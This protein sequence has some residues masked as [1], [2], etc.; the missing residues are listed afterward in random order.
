PAT[1]APVSAPLTSA[2]AMASLITT[3]PRSAA[4]TSLNTPPNAPIGVRQ[5]LR[6]TVSNSL[7]P[8]LYVLRF[9]G[10]WRL[11]AG[12]IA[13]GSPRR[14][15]NTKPRKRAFLRVF[16]SSCFRVDVVRPRLLRLGPDAPSDDHRRRAESCAGVGAADLARRAPR[17]LHAVRARQVEGQQTRHVDLDR[18]RGRLERPSLS[19]Q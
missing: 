15:E 13:V 14:H 1:P 6:I 17:A 19:R 4:D 9:C 11:N 18:R 10:F 16:V 3:A 8:R 2:R 5:A 7:M 12:S